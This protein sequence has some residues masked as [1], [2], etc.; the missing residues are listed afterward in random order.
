MSI[1][2]KLL[3]FQKLGVSIKK[4][5]NNPHFKSKYADLS[6]VINKVRPALSEVGITLIQASCETGL[7][8]TLYDDKTDTAITGFLPFIGATDPQKLGSN[9]TYL[10]RYSLV[11]MLGLE[12]DDDDGNT[13]AVKPPAKTVPKR[14]VPP[15]MSI[16]EA[17][18]HLRASANLD[19]LKERYKAL[20]KALREDNEVTAMK[21]ELKRILT[22]L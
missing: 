13:A 11:T 21:D 15:T 18:A 3:A 17:C 22:N 6:E 19:Q 8:T 10:R 16:G 1:Y 7:N 5:A 9:L 2:K 20:P 4:D 12:D 14:P